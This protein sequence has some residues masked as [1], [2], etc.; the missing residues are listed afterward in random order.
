MENKTF[1]K[2]FIIHNAENFVKELSKMQCG[3][4][5]FAEI[6]AAD[7]E[8]PFSEVNPIDGYG[9]PVNKETGKQFPHCCKFHNDV[10]TDAKGWFDR[11]PSCCELHR[12]LLLTNWFNKENYKDVPMKIVQQISFTEYHIVKQIELPDWY[13]D[14][15]DYIHSNVFVVF[16]FSGNKK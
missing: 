16:R 11:F 10:F 7:F 1:T 4:K 13:K 8:I 2:T 6:S 15:T 12:K 5:P 14:I 3:E 9:T